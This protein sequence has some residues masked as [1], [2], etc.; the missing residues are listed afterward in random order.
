MFDS[1]EQQIVT[2]IFSYQPNKFPLNNKSNI[3]TKYIMQK[4]S[5]ALGLLCLFNSMIFSPIHAEQLPDS[6]S[7]PAKKVDLKVMPY[8]SYNRTLGAQI[9]VVPL[10]MYKLSAKDTISPQSISGGC[11]MYTTNKSLIGVQFNKFFFDEDRYRVVL[12]FGGGDVNA[13][14]YFDMPS[15]VGFS[16]MNVGMAFFK[17]EIQRRLIDHL[18]FG[19]NYTYSK[20]KTVFELPGIPSKITEMN[21]IGTSLNLDNRN[22]VYYPTAGNLISIKYLTNPAAFNDTP[23]DRLEIDANKYIGVRDNIDVVALRFYSGIALGKDINFN[24]QFVVGN[25][26]LR[27]YTQGKYRGRQIA[28]IQGEYRFNFS[29]R[30]GMTAFGGTAMVFNSDNKDFNNKL[31]PAGGLGIRYVAFPKTHM[32][33]GLDFAVGKDDWGI[34]F[35][36][37]EAF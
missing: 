2:L 23:T 21:G 34:N 27:G 20:M 16:D 22:D 30:V 7:K 26:D 36:I 12:A 1:L 17:T 9:G 3:S 33:V 11:V 25:N 35:K 18:Y 29:K 19:L 8:I 13:Q 15:Y 32:N 37:G 24:Q 5:V 4:K 28:A 14:A 10:A 31:L 6:V